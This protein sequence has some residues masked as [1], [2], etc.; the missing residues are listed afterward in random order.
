MS[1]RAKNIFARIVFIVF[2][3]LICQHQFC[4]FII[5]RIVLSGPSGI[6]SAEYYNSVERFQNVVCSFQKNIATYSIARIVAAF[7]NPFIG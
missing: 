6:G 3:E 5:T 7:S 4:F 1:A 2:Q